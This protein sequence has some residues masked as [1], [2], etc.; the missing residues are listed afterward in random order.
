VAMS[1]LPGMRYWLSVGPD[2]GLPA[3]ALGADPDLRWPCSRQY[4][5]LK[6]VTAFGAFQ[7]HNGHSSLSPLEETVETF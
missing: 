6:L 5:S 1:G 4:E 7:E 3:P 2:L